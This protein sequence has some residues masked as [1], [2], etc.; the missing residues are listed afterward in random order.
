MEI[1]E[2]RDFEQIKGSGVLKAVTVYSST[3][4][5]LY[6]G[7][8]MGYEY[9]L[10]VLLAEH[11]GLEL[12]I[13]IAKDMEDLIDILN[14][15]EADLIAAGMTITDDRSELVSFTE[16]LYLT[17]QVLVQQ[18]PEDWYRLSYE[19][20]RKDLLKDPV[21]LIGDTVAV[22]TT[23]SYYDRL[24][25]LQDELGGW[26][27]IDT[28]AGNQPTEKLIEMVALGELKLT[29]ADNNIAQMNAGFY[30]NLDVSVPVSLSQR[31]GW[32]VRQ[33][34]PELL[35]SINV[36]ILE[37]KGSTTYNVIYNKYYQSKSSHKKR[38]GSEFF[39]QK[40]GKISQYDAIVRQFSDSLGWDWRLVSSLIY[41]ESRFD[42]YTS[43]WVGAGGLM[44]LMPAT[45]KE[46][47]VYSINDPTQNI[48][49]GTRYLE[50][51]WEN[52]AEI[53][54]SVQR[55]KFAMASYNCGYGHVLD[56]QRLTEKYGL[57]P[58][59]WDENVE[60]YILKLTYSEYYND[61]AVYYGY[62]RGMEPYMYV[63]EIFARF[64]HYEVFI[65]L[66]PSI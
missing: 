64:E 27:A 1:A 4:Y 49:G 40:T 45:A 5:F 62:V 41:Q 38:V 13:I 61:D 34:A 25:N 63:K 19:N 18:L 65:P 44:Q 26:F 11:L 59:V 33:N 7:Q 37:N 10:L 39:S 35:D 17:H 22:R 3:S 60:E 29:V 23:T 21:D 32:A 50:Q 66:D 6:K 48:M 2:H 51:M 47:G 14:N 55:I 46:L 42:P 8:P 57:D 54:D 58:L 9:E 36:W 30:P 15:G 12:E 56:A 53:P 28:I 20:A 31:I 16:T 52:W 24:L 43:S